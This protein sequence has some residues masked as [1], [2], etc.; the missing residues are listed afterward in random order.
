MNNFIN[1]INKNSFLKN[2]FQKENNIKI[3]KIITLSISSIFLIWLHFSVFGWHFSTKTKNQIDN[4]IKT[5]EGESETRLKRVFGNNKDILSK[6]TTWYQIK[7]TFPSYLEGLKTTLILAIDSLIIGFLLATLY[8]LIKNSQS[9]NKIISNINKGITYFLDTLFF[10]LKGI[11]VAAQAML[12]FYGI[13]YL[14]KDLFEIKRLYAGLFVLV[15]NSLA[16]ITVI[17]MQNIK[18]LDKGQIEAAHSLGMKKKQVFF[19]IVFP[20]T[21]KR[22]V[23]FIVQQFITN[24]KDSSFFAIIG[25]TELS[26]QAQS[27][28]GST[29]N[30]IL[31]FVMISFFYLSIISIANLLNKI[32]NKNIIYK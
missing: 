16:N 22:S 3:F 18:F 17:L 14:C 27:N 24:I 1:F 20:Q 5:L 28:M 11:P 10:I 2:I 12:V 13:G 23:P 21:L 29:F 8:I 6:N 25:I 30:P 32:F 4:Q 9:N 26:W 7:E 19:S 15:I 31:P